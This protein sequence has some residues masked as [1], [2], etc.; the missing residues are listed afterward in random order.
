[1]KIQ[2]KIFFYRTTGPI[3]INLGTKYSWVKEIQVCSNEGWCPFPRENNIV[4]M[5]EKH[6]PSLKISFFRTTGPVSTKLGTKHPWV[7][8]IQ[9]CSNEG[10][11]PFPRGDNYQI[12]KIH[13]QILKIYSSRTAGPISTKLGIIH[14]WV[15]GIQ[16]CSN[17]G[18]RPFLRKLR[19]CIDDLKKS[20]PEPLGQFQPNLAKI[21]LGSRVCKIIQMKGQSSFQWGEDYEIVKIVWQNFE[22]FY[23]S[24][25]PISTKF[26]KK[27][28]W[29]K[30][31]WVCSDGKAT[32]FYIGRYNKIAKVLSRNL[33]IFSSWNTGSVL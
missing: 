28:P 25:E 2:W 14:P 1:M 30:S 17:E 7:K 26:G 6:L 32:P 23:S 3:L 15:R 19:K 33:K 16:V 27:H 5:L 31:I 22:I 24:T 12:A 11:S 4:K 9:V 21:I 10:P 18:L 13:W 29:L 8:G 20:S